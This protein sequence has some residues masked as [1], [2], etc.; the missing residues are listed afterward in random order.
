MIK[1]KKLEYQDNNVILEGFYA[2][3]DAHTNKRPAVLVAHDWSGRNELADNKAIML[4]ELGYVG[5]AIDMYGEG[6]VGQS[7]DEKKSLMMPIITH[8][9]LLFQRIA[10]AFDFVKT[11]D[12]VDVKKTGA[13]G[14]CFGGLC[15]LDL[16]RHGVDIS[17][18]VSFHGLL[19]APPSFEIIAPLK[20]KIL[21]LHGHDDPMV[22]PED[23]L[24]FENE[25][26][27]AKSDW[28]VHV[29]SNTKHAFTNPQANDENLGTIYN[30]QSAQRSYLAM[31]NFFT[32]IFR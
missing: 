30:K 3:D 21:V 23:V 8:R 31:Q 1:T 20:P 10:C 26:T 7:T 27:K 16:A 13:I 6:K 25:M 28:Q 32:E 5:F 19:S 2:Y 11:L 29:Y 12:Y 15:V 17:G 24:T 9:D 18:V 4:A 22:T 14:F